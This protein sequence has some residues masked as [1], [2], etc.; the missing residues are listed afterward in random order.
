MM[1]KRIAVFLSAFIL[2]S[3]VRAYETTRLVIVKLPD[4]SYVYGLSEFDITI[5]DAGDDYAMALASD[6]DQVVLMAA[7]YEVEV[8][9]EDYQAYKDS[10]FDRG[11]YHTY[12]QVYDVLDSF[13]TDYPDICRLDTIGY[14]VQ[15][16]AIWAMRVTDNPQIEEH[17]PEIRLPANMHG[18]EHIGTEITLYFLRYLLTN[19]VTD[20]QARALVDSNEIWVLPT[21]NPDGKVA[22]TRRNANNVDLNRDYGYFWDSWGGSSSP[23]SQIE[24]KIMMQHLAENDIALE[25]NYHSVAQYVNYPWDYHYADPPDSQHIIALSQ[26]YA[27]SSGLTVTNGYDWYQVTGCLQ[28]YTFGVSGALAWTIENLEPSSSSS[29]D[30]IC[31]NN[32]D[33]LLG[34]CERTSWG[35]EGV[36]KDSANNS[37]LHARIECMNPDRVD[38]YNDPE[39]GDF[40]KMIEPGTYDLRVSANGYSPKVINDVSVPSTGSVSIGDVLLAPDTAYYYAFRVVI[41]RYADHAEQSNRTQPRSA[42]GPDDGAFFSLGQSGYVVLDMG[43]RSPIGNLPGDDITVYEGDDHIA[44]GYDVFVNNDW[45]GPWFSCGSATGTASFDLSVT[46]LSQARY[47]KIVDDGS[48]SS[49][50][51]AGFD[52]DAVKGTPPADVTPPVSPFVTKAEKTGSDVKLYWNMVTTDTSGSTETMGRY[53]IYRS[54]V[55]D[56]I[57]AS[58]DS[59]GGIAHPDTEYTD[60][61]ALTGVTSYYYLIKAVD[62]ASN[63]SKKSNMAYAVRKAVNEN[64]VA[65]DRNWS[66]LP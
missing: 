17:E 60:T 36:V 32:R 53:V 8:I 10:I 35:I 51:S 11:F 2:C 14:S 16:R 24:N 59:I 30:L 64:P 44:E 42:L 46:G 15:N 66:I 45:D 62:I 9:I 41:C 6:S 47:V 18:D 56:F 29:I 43:S 37:P 49:G 55:P 7:G 33:A 26:I 25:Y 19:Y 22:N 13:A 65:T 1:M 3:V 57:P 38:V 63:Q 61:G 39:L 20:T 34:V 50:K 5:L 12:D 28:D 31:A 21:I 23:S 48:A 58:P 52:V 54:T 4:H 27:D 40:H